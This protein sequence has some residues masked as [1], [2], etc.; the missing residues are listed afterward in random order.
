M[1]DIHPEALRL[2]RHFEGFALEPY[3]DAAGFWTVDTGHLMTRDRS[4]QRPA[5]VSAERAEDLFRKNAARAARSVL[6]LI[7]V[8]LTDGQF[9][10]LASF[11]FNLGGGAL[12]ASTLRRRVNEGAHQ[13]AAR[14]F[15]R[16]VFAGGRRLRGLVRRRR[17]EAE[18]YLS[19]LPPEGAA[20]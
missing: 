1:R 10:A 5:P 14:E 3:R 18:M 2:I 19:H 7:R 17:A 9:G 20:R 6:R 12:R 11:A 4:A 16:W 13:E 15:G 8:P